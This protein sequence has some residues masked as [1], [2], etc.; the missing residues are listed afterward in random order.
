MINRHAYLLIPKTLANQLLEA[1]IMTSLELSDYLSKISDYIE[2]SFYKNSSEIME[3]IMEN[4]FSKVCEIL[5]IN[6]LEKGVFECKTSW[7]IDA[8]IKFLKDVVIDITDE[9]IF[10]TEFI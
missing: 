8:G 9:M 7:N 5:E 2:Y 4:E 10:I 6:E 3:A 1:V